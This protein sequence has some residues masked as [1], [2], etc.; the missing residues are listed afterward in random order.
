MGCYGIGVGRIVACLIENNIIY[1]NDKLKGFALP[2][3]IAPYKVQIIYKEDK[4]EQAFDLYEKL[5][6]LGINCIIDDREGQSI[7]TKIKDVYVL[8]TPYIIVI[9]NNYDGDTYEIEE[10][11]SGFKKKMTFDEIVSLY[12]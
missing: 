3:E 5:L 8:G 6:K 11:K 12:K 2:V 7:G 1:E 9:G 4:K 10:I